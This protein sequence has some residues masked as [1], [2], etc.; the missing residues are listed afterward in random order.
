MINEASNNGNKELLQVL[1]Q[2]KDYLADE[3]RWY[4]IMLKALA[5]GSLAIILDGREVGRVIRKYA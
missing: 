2:I 4:R 3:D 5:D 1:H